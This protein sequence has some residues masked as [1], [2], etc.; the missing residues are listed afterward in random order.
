MCIIHKDM[1]EHTPALPS[2]GALR[3]L[4][5]SCHIVVEEHS[6]M[7]WIPINRFHL[8]QHGPDQVFVTVNT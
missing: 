3:P 6:R 7:D 2:G 1:S 8:Q 4:E 5:C